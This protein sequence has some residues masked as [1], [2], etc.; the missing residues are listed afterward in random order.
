M[1]GVDRRRA[2]RRVP[3]AT[4][5]TSKLRLRT[6]RELE[7]VNIGPAGVLVEATARLLPG[8]WVDV[9]VITID[10]RELVRSRVVRAW[11]CHVSADAILY[12]GAL[13]FDRLTAVAIV[14]P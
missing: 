11:V 6:G 1:N 3:H 10:G 5:P 7:V 13:A 4:E 2:A 14:P 9:H 8:T 12:R